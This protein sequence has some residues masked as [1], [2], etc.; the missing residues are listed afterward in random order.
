MPKIIEIFQFISLIELEHK[1]K[2]SFIVR[3]P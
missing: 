1:G 2:D 3:C